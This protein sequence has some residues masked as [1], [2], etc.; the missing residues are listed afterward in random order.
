MV[1]HESELGSTIHM[2]YSMVLTTH[3]SIWHNT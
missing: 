1:H 2:S 3:K